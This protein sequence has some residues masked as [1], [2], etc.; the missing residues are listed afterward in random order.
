MS[1]FIVNSNSQLS[2]TVK[3]SGSKNS[4]L[5]ILCATLLCT[6]VS[7][8]ENIPDITDIK[9][10][11]EILSLLGCKITRNKNSLTIDST[12]ASSNPIPY[13]LSGKIRASFIVAGSLISRFKNAQIALPG[14]CTIGTRPVDLHLKGFSLLGCKHHIKD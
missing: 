6:G 14:G 9:V 13:E 5:P 2:G 12:N 11:C 7:K 3:V 10:M 4:A 1:K 8:L